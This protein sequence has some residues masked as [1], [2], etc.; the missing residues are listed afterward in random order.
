MD[1]ERRG[2]IKIKKGLMGKGRDRLVRA[3]SR[4]DQG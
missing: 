1:K 2:V 4:E 3:F